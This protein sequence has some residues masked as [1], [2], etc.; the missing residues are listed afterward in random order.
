MIVLCN[1]MMRSGSTL[2]YNLVKDIL[3]EANVNFKQIGFLN[4]EE[5]EI[6]N[7]KYKN[8][9]NEKHKIYLIKSHEF[10]FLNNLENVY[11]I[12][13]YRNLFDVA[14]S[15]KRKFERKGEE[16]IK[17]LEKGVSENIKIKKSKKIISQEYENLINSLENCVQEITIFLSI[18]LGEIAIEKI[19]EKNSVIN[20]IKNQNDKK[21]F[22]I[23]YKIFQTLKILNK[24]SKRIFTVYIGQNFIK[25]IKQWLYPHDKNSL[26]HRNHISKNLGKDG[27]WKEILDE[28]EIKMIQDRFKLKID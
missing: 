7:N 1:G 4:K 6:N 24:S 17:E 14:G 15:L 9:A 2:Q 25:K 21:S 18:E 8:Y 12:Y 10:T 19:S 28:Q 5:I 20:T 27:M 13:S 26:L 11:T 22:Q 16:L 23:K 3:I